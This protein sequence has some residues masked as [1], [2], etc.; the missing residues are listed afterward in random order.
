M[1][2]LIFLEIEVW[3][4]VLHQ[5]QEKVRQG[6]FILTI[7]AEEEMDNDGLG[8]DE[9]I[10]AILS[11]EIQGRQKDRIT[12]GWKYRI[13]GESLTGDDI[14]VVAKIGA[15]GKAVIITVYKL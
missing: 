14:E 13:Q 10:Q 6:K 2:V 5:I 1:N 7:H 12:P 4:S 15:T 9:V 8:L 3:E 11:G